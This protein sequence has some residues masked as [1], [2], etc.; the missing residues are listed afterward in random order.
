MIARWFVWFAPTSMCV[1]VG[2][3]AFGVSPAGAAQTLRRQGTFGGASSTVVDPYPLS[4]PQGVAVDE[5]S[6]DVYVAD[7]GNHRVEKFSAT[8]QFLLAFGGNVGGPGVDVCGGAVACV[9]GVE[10]SAPGDLAAPL[11]VA[12]DNDPASPSY[13]DVYVADTGD[14][15][16][17]KFKPDG[18][19]EALWGTNGQLS[20]S[21]AT[22]FGSIAGIA[23]GTTGTLYVANTAPAHT[24]ATVFEFKPGSELAGEVTL[25][26]FGVSA[27]GL[28]VNAT[29]D[30]FVGEAAGTAIEEYGPLG[31]GLGE[32]VPYLTPINVLTVEPV[33]GELY[34]VSGET[35][36]TLTSSLP[37][38]FV[39]SGVAAAAGGDVFLS[40]AG[41]G[42]VYRYGPGVAAPEAEGLSVGDVTAT[43]A[44]L[45][46]SVNPGGAVSS[47]VFE[48][49]PVGGVFV[50]VPGAGGGGVVGEAGEAGERIIPVTFHVQ[51]LQPGTV[52]EFRV[53]L[54]N[55]AGSFVSESSSFT[56]EVAGGGLVRPD[57]RQW[58]LVSPAD[59]HGSLLEGMQYEGGV[60]QAAVGGDA[61]T[62]LA[63]A[64]TEGEPPGYAEEEQVLSTRGPDGWVSR[65]ISPPHE[66]V[67]P[68]SVGNGQE[69]RVFSEDL[70]L[71]V[72]QPRGVFEPALSTEASEQTAYLRTNFLNGNVN[73]PCTQSCYRPLV[74]GKPG[75]ANVAPGTAFGQEGKC[76]P[77]EEC[78]PIFDGATPDLSRIALRSEPALLA[79]SG[80]REEYEWD[81]GRLSA[82]N[83]LPELRVS[84]SEDGSWSYSVGTSLSVSHG[85]VTKLIAVPSGADSPD[86]S[87]LA[88][89]TSRVSPDGRWFAFMSQQELTGYNTHDAVSGQPDEEVY[90]YHAPENLAS[91]TGTLVCVSCNPTG[92]RPVGREAEELENVEHGLAVNGPWEEESHEWIAA[93]V[94]G[95]TPYELK[96]AVYQSRYLSDS[97]RL[98]FDSNDALVPQD[99]NGNED[100]Y[101][102]EPPGV[103]DCTT[104]STLYSPRSGG[105]VGLISSGQAT[106]ESAF[107]DASGSGGDVF[108]L[109]TGRLVPQDYDNAL[110]VYDAHECRSAAPCFPEPTVVPRPCE[111]GDACK[112]AP[113]PQPAIYGSP[114]SETFSGA[115]NVTPEAPAATVKGKAKGSAGAQRLAR[116]LRSCRTKRRGRRACERQARARFARRSTGAAKK[117]RG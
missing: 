90:L 53:S 6:E 85:G 16:V 11:F 12:V 88:D 42:K 82:G 96:L 73:E 61:M 72:V 37:V 106:G 63:S 52:Y 99:V 87:R 102:Y 62:Y 60:F 107:L 91:E 110:D 54:S 31:E 104:A 46:A 49:A 100:V 80:E 27:R 108:F 112:P 3:L 34:W 15:T 58:E 59:K 35:L 39:G 114:S 56:T 2:A 70:S 40:N 92:A 66:H 98:F 94:P 64:P 75:Y 65:D 78:G 5:A 47:Y 9:A 115:G 71:A 83:H 51:G 1:L 8:G 93:N 74:T 77:Q 20:A 43:S 81:E 13:H 32:V 68:A 23:V 45:E 109:T 95:W 89:R 36:N 28:G 67:T 14:K 41:A 57:G 116:A 17:S 29:G 30:L 84:T 69:Y 10:G 79:G 117:G 22:P 48:Y 101:E 111:T 97:G 7:A 21:G 86:W 19:L 18:E 24:G 33:S 25:L 50:P 44:T 103:G 105:C 4:N 38:G 26:G 113:T 76:P 55:S